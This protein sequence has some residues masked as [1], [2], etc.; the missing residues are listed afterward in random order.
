MHSRTVPTPCVRLERPWLYLIQTFLG[1]YIICVCNICDSCAVSYRVP[2][3][4]SGKALP[5]ARHTKALGIIDG[6]GG[7]GGLTRTQGEK[8]LQEMPR[9]S[10]AHT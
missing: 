5:P 1:R 3:F 6:L 9:W 7:R 10:A 8:G 2:Y 4:I